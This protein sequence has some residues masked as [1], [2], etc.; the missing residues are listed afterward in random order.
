MTEMNRITALTGITE[1]TEMTR[2][3]IY[4]YPLI[5]TPESL[6]KV[7]YTSLES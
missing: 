3:K 7:C 6:N 2:T 1:V 5:G 4:A